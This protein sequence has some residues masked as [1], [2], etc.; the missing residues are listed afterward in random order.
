MDKLA[1]LSIIRNYYPEAVISIDNFN[2]FIDFL[3]NDLGLHP[4]QIMM[5]DSICS[6]DVNSIQYPARINEF[7]GPFKLG[8]LDGFP[9]SGLTGMTA[10][11]KHVPEDGAVFIYYGPHIGINKEGIVGEI[12]RYGQRYT[13]P[14]C[15]ATSAAL[16][17]LENDQ[18]VPNNITELDYQMNTIEQLLLSERHRIIFAESP[19]MEATEVIYEAIDKRIEQL[20]FATEYDCKYI[21]LMGVIMVNGDSGLGSFNVPKRFE[22]IDVST[23]QKR[24]LHI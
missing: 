7:L 16:F 24:A 8:G 21:I 17:K 23:K 12:N 22:L 6:D 20:V 2:R 18:I 5:A 1:K 10:F 11:S 9:F 13:T 3:K 15:G 4:S 19:I 14:C